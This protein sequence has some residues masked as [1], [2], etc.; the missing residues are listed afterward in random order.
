MLVLVTTD[1]GDKLIECDIFDE[2]IRLKPHHLIVLTHTEGTANWYVIGEPVHH[3]GKWLVP[4]QLVEEADEP[5][6]RRTGHIAHFITGKDAEL[7]ES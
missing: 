6:A 2:T 1:T 4:L 7:S 5:E 3:K